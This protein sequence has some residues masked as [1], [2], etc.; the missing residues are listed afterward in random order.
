MKKVAVFAVCDYVFQPNGG[1]V[2]L[3]NNFLSANQTENVRYYLVG[4]SFD[5]KEMVGVW[6]KKKI[7]STVYDFLPV[8]KVIKDKEKTHIPFRLRMAL[9]IRKY[10]EKITEINPDFCY[11][12]APELAIP[13]WDK[14][15]INLVYH[16]HGDPCQTLAISRFP[17]FRMKFFSQM[18]WKVIEKT[19]HKSN[20][21]VWAA[22]RAKELY[23]MQQ[24]HMEQV[25]EPKSC[26]IHSS[27]DTNLVSNFER[28]QNLRNRMHLVTVGRLSHV[29]RIDFIIDAFSELLK[30]GI[31]ADLLIC[32]DGEE[33]VALEKQ[34]EKRNVAERVIFLGL[35][36]RELIATALKASEAFLFASENEA[37]SLVVLESLYMGTPVVSTNVGDIAD[38]VIDGKTGYIIDGYQA[39]LYVDAI[40]ELLKNGKDQ[41]SSKC[42]KMAEQYTPKIM[43][44][45]INEVFQ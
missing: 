37:M 14:K 1:E 43:A 42:A 41:Y 36:D 12:H 34:A 25:V 29:K 31:D 16:V 38:A 26:V 44:D 45:R 24:S 13:M 6:G 39:D 2:I 4:M 10:W 21:I 7:G 5:E 33:R 35:A 20:K 3:L 18:Y 40:K 27:F 19:M 17:I 15:N 30:D 9:G 28:L 23:Y 11:V 22:R 32:G 8:T